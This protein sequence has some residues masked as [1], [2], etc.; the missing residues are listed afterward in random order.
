MTLPDADH[1]RVAV[2]EVWTNPIGW[3]LRL[4][5]D[6][7]SLPIATV[8]GSADAKRALVQT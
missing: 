1:A 4:T 5:I 8:V 7:T 3:E 6:G 2:C